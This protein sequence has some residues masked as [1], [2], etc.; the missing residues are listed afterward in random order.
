MHVYIHV[1]LSYNRTDCYGAVQEKL[2]VAHTLH[3]R[4]LFE[5]ERNELDVILSMTI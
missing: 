2:K 4:G 5:L 1:Y 3:R